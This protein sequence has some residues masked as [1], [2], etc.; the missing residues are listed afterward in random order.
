[1]I[2]VKDNTKM[3]AK[4]DYSFID[5]S[6][7]LLIILFPP[8]CGEETLRE[9]KVSPLKIVIKAHTEKREWRYLVLAS[10]TPSLIL[11]HGQKVWYLP[12]STSPWHAC[13]TFS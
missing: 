8:P 10:P 7:N 1:M 12:L 4:D 3:H 6:S 5:T 2:Q 11:L 13:K 9:E